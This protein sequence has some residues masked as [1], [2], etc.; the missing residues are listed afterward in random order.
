MFAIQGPPGTGKTT[1]SSKVIA[2]LVQK[3][4]RVAITSNSHKVIDN[5]LLKIDTHF[6]DHNIQKLIVK[7]DTRENE[8]FLNSKVLTLPPKKI[9]N[10][11][12]VMGATTNKFCSKEID[13]KF[14]LLVVDEAGQYALANL[15]TIAKHSKSIL[16]V[17]DTQ[18]LA[19]PTKASHPNN[20]GQSCLNY[21][22][23]GSEVVP[24][25]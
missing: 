2:D 9:G 20:S 10:H 1:L 15:L 23:N 14:D 6:Q 22:M 13:S 12:S 21:L 19:M 18:Q 17:G 11:I 8:I 4:F 3:G 25:N 24:N 16:L 7:C 5:L